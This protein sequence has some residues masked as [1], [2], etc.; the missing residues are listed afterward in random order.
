[1][2]DSFIRSRLLFLGVLFVALLG[3]LWSF[4][5]EGQG[6]TALN[7]G[8]P[9]LLTVAFLDVGQGDAIFIETP[10]GVQVLIDG[11]PNVSVLREL[12]KQ[13]PL[14]DKTID[15][16]L[17]THAD[18]DHIGGLVDVLERYEVT[19]IVRTEATNDT[20]VSDAFD[21]VVE[22]EN[23][24]VVFARV[25]QQLV[26]GA[27]TTLRIFSPASDPSDL[28]SNASSIIAQL[29]YGEIEFMLTGDA[30]SN[31]EE[32]LV[33]TFGDELESEVLKLGHHGSKTS[34]S[35]NF[36]AT[37]KPEYGVISAEI[38]NRYGHPH[39]EVVLRANEFDVKLSNTATDGTIIF[40]SDGKEVW[41]E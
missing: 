31:I 2:S 26:I 1:M 3:S 7:A 33:K 5:V 23:A 27:S 4:L 30:P 29:R 10:D 21:L 32:Y 9:G 34:T 38:G 14:L 37:V 24:E 25:G 28:E 17:A 16:V 22:E 15:V 41:K 36:L 39:H 12:P 19:T 13:M 18:K 11:G 8:E 40:K 20:G 35:E 6:A